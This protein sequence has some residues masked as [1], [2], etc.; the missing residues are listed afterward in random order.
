MTG[1]IEEESL[2]EKGNYT[3]PPFYLDLTPFK[4]TDWHGA[5]VS[6]AHKGKQPHSSVKLEEEKGGMS[7]FMDILETGPR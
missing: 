5:K 1:T 4:K 7:T 6:G 2:V 3:L